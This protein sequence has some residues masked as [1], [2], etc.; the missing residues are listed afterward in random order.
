MTN[1]EF[2]AL[3]SRILVNT[4]KW[5]SNLELTLN[6]GRFRSIRHSSLEKFVIFLG[7]KLL[8]CSL[9]LLAF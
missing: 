5:K 8:Y 3:P 4:N 7:I 1:D 2:G 9:N 6:L